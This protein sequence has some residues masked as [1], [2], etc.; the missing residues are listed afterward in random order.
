MNL[1]IKRR[2][3][4]LATLVLA[5]GVA[6]FVNWYYTGDTLSASEG[7][8]TTEAKYIQNLGEAQYVNAQENSDG[9]AQARLSRQKS[10]DEALEKLEK[11]LEDVEEGSEEGKKLTASIEKLTNEI[12]KESDAETLVSTRLSTECVVVINE[13][14]A[15]VIV[16]KGVLNEDTALQI[17][18]M[19]SESTR[20]EY[21][22]IRI[23]EIK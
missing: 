16:D 4:I 3:L 2:Q 18:E 13:D 14:K 17:M 19:V 15:Q 8:E 12:K 23:T 5:L 21:E 6:V 1:L 10:R 22:N 9:F 11:A 7:E 20:L